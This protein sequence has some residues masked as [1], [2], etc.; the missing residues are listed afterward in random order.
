MR[1]WYLVYTKPQ[2]ER[3]AKLHLERQGFAVYL[4]LMRSRRRRGGGAKERTEL[5]FPRYLFLELDDTTDNWGPIRSTTGVASLVSF[6]QQAAQVPAG[7][8]DALRSREDEQGFQPIPSRPLASGDRIRIREGA[9]DGYEA[10]FEART[11]QSRVVLL[12]EVA[13]K[14]ARL[15]VDELSI[16]AV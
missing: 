11:G 5:M 6:A 3:T 14:L 7:L 10:I 8:I 12:L 9:F 16:E 2:G 4:P 1:A 13:G 15:Q